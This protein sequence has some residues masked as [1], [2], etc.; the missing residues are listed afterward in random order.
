MSLDNEHLPI[1]RVLGLA[2]K[3]RVTYYACFAHALGD[4]VGAALFASCFYFW[5]GKQEDPEGWIY[6]TQAEITKE[7]GMKRSMQETARKKLVDV[8]VLED[9][10]RGVPGKLHYRFFWDKLN[11]IL[12]EHFLEMERAEKGK[13]RKEREQ[14]QQPPII[15]AMAAIFDEK[16]FA[17]NDTE[18]AWG[19]KS[20]RGKQFGCIKQLH[21]LLAER[22]ANR[23]ARA[24]QQTGVDLTASD[25]QFQASYEELLS[26]WTAFLDNLPTWHRQKA[27][28]PDLLCSNFSKIINE[29][30]QA[31]ANVNPAKNR[32]SAAATVK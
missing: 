6:K 14:T 26:S 19:A 29:V 17:Q 9:K 8:G 22:I 3:S 24:A 12:S 27:F 20:D 23:K 28:S 13:R 30:Q 21:D 31:Q 5:E 32:T 2:E 15:H 25:A 4:D 18:F 11:E 16:Y 10:V 7:T 1:L